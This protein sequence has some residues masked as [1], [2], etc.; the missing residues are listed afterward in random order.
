[1]W[2][3]QHPL[4][5]QGK[6]QPR[7]VEKEVVVEKVVNSGLTDE[8]VRRLQQQAFDDYMWPDGLEQMLRTLPT[9]KD[10]ENWFSIV[11]LH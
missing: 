1:M 5:Q 3:R 7:I 10:L 9:P 6:F 8:D 11:L 4:I 2:K